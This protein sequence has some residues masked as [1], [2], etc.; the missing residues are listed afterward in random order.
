MGEVAVGG[1]ALHM[2]AFQGPACAEQ[3]F[4]ERMPHTSSFSSANPSPPKQTSTRH[5]IEG[6]NLCSFALQ[7]LLALSSVAGSQLLMSGRLA[8]TTGVFVLKSSC[9]GRTAVE[10]ATMTVLAGLGVHRD[11]PM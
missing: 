5:D 9:V 8:D 1:V 4:P 10:I 7:E 2:A 3:G 6:M 11:P